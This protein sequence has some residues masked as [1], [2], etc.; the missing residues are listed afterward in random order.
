MTELPTEVERHLRRARRLHDRGYRARIGSNERKVCLQ[1]MKE[2]IAQAMA[3]AA[4]H[5]IPLNLLP[6]WARERFEEK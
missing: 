3:I 1:S 5:G 2:H 6:E 4:G